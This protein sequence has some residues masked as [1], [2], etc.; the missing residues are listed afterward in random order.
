MVRRSQAGTRQV[1][2]CVIVSTNISTIVKL[3]YTFFYRFRLINTAAREALVKGGFVKTAETGTGN[4]GK[5]KVKDKKA[6]K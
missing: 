4:S 3:T 1:G 5:A 6:K 2:R